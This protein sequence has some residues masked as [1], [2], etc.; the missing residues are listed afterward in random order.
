MAPTYPSLPPTHPGYFRGGSVFRAMT[1]NC[2]RPYEPLLPGVINGFY[3]PYGYAAMGGV[4]T[5]A[6]AGG[7]GGYGMGGP[8]HGIGFG[9]PPQPLLR[10]SLSPLGKPKD[11]KGGGSAVKF[12]SFDRRISSRPSPSFKSLML[13]SPEATS[14]SFQK[15]GKLPL[16]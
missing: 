5:A 16:S 7:Y 4:P 6:E 12:D 13:R 11:Y 2:P 8:M 3:T 1:A 9:V 15:F 14:P 10:S